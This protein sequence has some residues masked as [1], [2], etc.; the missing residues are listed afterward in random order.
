MESDYDIYNLANHVFKLI[1]EEANELS[2]AEIF[3]EKNNYIN[4][5][6]E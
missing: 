6:I 4:I 2:C 3:Y 1:D 5:D